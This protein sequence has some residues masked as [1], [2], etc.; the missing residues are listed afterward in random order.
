MSEEVLVAEKT[1]LED[2]F[3]DIAKDERKGYQGYVV[4]AEKLVE[5]ATALRDE[6]GYDFLSSVTG[7]DY[8][9]EGRMKSRSNEKIPLCLH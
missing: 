7:V 1:E 2:R 3:P 9:P 5:F 6:F 8:M 4:P